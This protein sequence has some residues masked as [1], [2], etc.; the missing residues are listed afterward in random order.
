MR[1][2]RI[3][4][5][6]LRIRYSAPDLKAAESANPLDRKPHLA[7]IYGLED[8]GPLFIEED[9]PRAMTLALNCSSS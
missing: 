5:Q 1:A 8:A 6:A 4:L 2:Q 9:A 3:W 7:T